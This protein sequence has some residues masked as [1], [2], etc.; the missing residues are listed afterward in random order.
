MP[1]NRNYPDASGYAAWYAT[2][3]GVAEGSISRS[4]M[5]GDADIR[6]TIGKEAPEGV[7]PVSAF[8]GYTPIHRIDNPSDGIND[9]ANYVVYFKNESDEFFKATNADFSTLTQLTSGAEFDL[10][11]T[12]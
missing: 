6:G 12:F 5:P 10:C 4:G 1:D 11:Q 8:D 2:K 3:S 9:A 7:D